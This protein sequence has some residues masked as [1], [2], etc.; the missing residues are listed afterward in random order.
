MNYQPTDIELR[1]A[2]RSGDAISTMRRPDQEPLAR[3]V[4]RVESMRDYLM[5]EPLARGV[6][7]E[8]GTLLGRKGLP[9]PRAA[10][11]MA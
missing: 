4:A 2:P 7:R 11:R 10:R 9:P 3:F 1:T 8:L 6:S 5:G